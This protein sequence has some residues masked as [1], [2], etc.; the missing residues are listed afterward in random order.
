MRVGN[1]E[2]PT[3]PSPSSSLPLPPGFVSSMARG[4]MV[5]RNFVWAVHGG[6]L[7]TQLGLSPR[8]TKE[9]APAVP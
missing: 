2:T 7:C 8:A 5:S 4:G 6:I 3:W 1:E 9:T